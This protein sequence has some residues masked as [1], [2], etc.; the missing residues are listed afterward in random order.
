MVVTGHC[1]TYDFI[2]Y[3]VQ[4]QSTLTQDEH[5][6]LKELEAFS[7]EGTERRV[8]EKLRYRAL[9]LYPPLDTFRQLQL[10]IIDW[11]KGWRDESDEGNRSTLFN[12]MRLIT[13]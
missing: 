11:G 5:T 9:D 1:G 13:C 10:P 7:K 3:L 8:S 12:G 4:V 2:C 6:T